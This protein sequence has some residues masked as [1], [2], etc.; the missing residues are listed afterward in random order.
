MINLMTCLLR[1]K[2]HSV[3]NGARDTRQSL[4]EHLCI[5]QGG[6][7]SVELMTFTLRNA[8]AIVPQPRRACTPWALST[9]T[10]RRPRAW[11]LEDLFKIRNDVTAEQ[12][13][14]VH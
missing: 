4:D 1:E 14:R 8:N 2:A 5:C 7:V 11:P 3:G 13:D 6:C 12:L 10:H 9:G